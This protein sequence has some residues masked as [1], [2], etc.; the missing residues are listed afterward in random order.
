MVGF[1]DTA[2]GAA[3]RE[4]NK[5]YANIVTFKAKKMN[6]CIMPTLLDYIGNRS[7]RTSEPRPE[8]QERAY[9]AA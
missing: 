3:A 8:P 9:R 6:H 1:D 2:A 7:R 4:S 5:V